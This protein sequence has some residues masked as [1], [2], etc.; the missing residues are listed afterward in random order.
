MDLTTT[1]IGE[2]I[3]ENYV[4]SISANIILWQRIQTRDNLENC[5]GQ[6]GAPSKVC[7]GGTIFL[8]G[9]KCPSAGGSKVINKVT[10]KV[11]H[12]SYGGS[13]HTVVVVPAAGGI[14]QQ[15]PS[16]V[17]DFTNNDNKAVQLLF[18]NSFKDIAGWYHIKGMVQN[19]GNTTLTLL[20]VPATIYNSA[21]TIID[22]ESAPAYTTQAGLLQGQTGTFELLIDPSTLNAQTPAFFKLGYQW[23]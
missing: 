5:P 11:I 7:P 6:P 17:T 13:S 8:I 15:I 23:Q 10:N 4:K 1:H 18:V 2:T 21:Q 3:K 14:M 20:T 19:S 12:E 16:L 9:V 22:T